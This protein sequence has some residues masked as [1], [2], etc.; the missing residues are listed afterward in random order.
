VVLAI[1]TQELT[2]DMK[3]DNMKNFR[4]AIT[5]GGTGGHF[6]PGLS[7]ARKLK[8]L[9][10][11][12]I[13]L[14]SG[15]N[16]DH[17]SEIAS[18]FGIPSVTI[19]SSPRPKNPIGALKF[20]ANLLYGVILGR[21]HLKTFNPDAFLAMGSFASFSSSMA[22]LSLKI[23][24]FLHDGNAKIGK[25]N[26]LLS[27]FARHM[28]LGFPPVNQEKIKCPA[29]Y[30]G[31]P[32]RKEVLNSILS[33]NDAITQINSKYS[34][35]LKEDLPLILIFGGSQGAATF[36]KN[37]PEAAVNQDSYNFQIIHLA[38]KGA[39]QEAGKIYGEK[40]PF[41]LLL[42]DSS[43]DMGLFYSAADF[44]ICRSG[45]STTAELACF[46]K[47][48]LMVPYPF[49]ADLHQNDNAAFYQSSGAA[50]VI[51]NSECTASR[52]KNAISNLIKN[53]ASYIE[54]GKSGLKLAL[55]NADL[56]TLKLIA[57]SLK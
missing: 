52:L 38:G 31:M 4:L 5:C 26:L 48:A 24:I 29:S 21:K 8:E 12:V 47:Y 23:P 42:L 36:N 17:Q 16:S 40:P 34:C 19:P 11:D 6:Y 2:S 43:P 37:I 27:R 18:N 22:A 56:D 3:N 55:P 46:G 45:G 49:A 13:I 57:D 1:N 15:K 50:E 35:N 32:V 25:A 39:A 33:K 9:G 20:I 28:A 53:S 44:V 14:L 10:G 51:S 54:K 7:I 41:P 30:T